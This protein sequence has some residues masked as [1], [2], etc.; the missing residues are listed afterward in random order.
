MRSRLLR[1]LGSIIGLL[2]I[3][4][5]TLAPT[6]SQALAANTRFETMLG[7]YCSASS[8]LRTH[9]DDHTD[10]HQ[11]GMG[12]WETCGYCNLAAHVPVLP[13]LPDA[14]LPLSAHQSG[15]LA[16]PVKRFAPYAPVFA[17]QPRAP[18]SSA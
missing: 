16:Q 1:K 12:H 13:P 17:A 7:V 4:M 10:L 11:G 2:A 3:L 14:N 15:P 18:P 6:V 9:A 5:T 8:G